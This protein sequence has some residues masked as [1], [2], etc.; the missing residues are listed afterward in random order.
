MLLCKA[1]GAKR[2]LPLP[3]SV[4]SHCELML[5]AGEKLAKDLESIEFSAPTC[6]LIQNV[7]AKAVADPSE[8][9]ANFPGTI[10]QITILEAVILLNCKSIP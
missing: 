2:T 4:P 10:L 8:L 5:P 7:S 1:A 3:V 6:T 9:K